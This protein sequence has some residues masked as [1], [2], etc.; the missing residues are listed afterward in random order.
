MTAVELVGFMLATKFWGYL[1]CYD[2]PPLSSLLSSLLL[3]SVSLLLPSVSC[4]SFFICVCC[5]LR[6]YGGRVRPW[7]GGGGISLNGG[8]GSNLKIS[9]QWIWIGAPFQVSV[10][11]DRKITQYT[12]TMHQH[13]IASKC[14]P[15]LKPHITR[16]SHDRSIKVEL[17]PRNTG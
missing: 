15:L 16:C 4:F 10:L 17:A 13:T 12:A 6:F 5:V 9:I 2:P 11:K 14:D 3:P 1:I 7:L 8:D